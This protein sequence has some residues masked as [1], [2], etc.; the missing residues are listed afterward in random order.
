MFILKTNLSKRKHH[1]KRTHPSNRTLH[2]TDRGSY[3]LRY[4]VLRTL[5]LA[6]DKAAGQPAVFPADLMEIIMYINYAKISAN[7]PRAAEEMIEAMPKL[8]EQQK[9]DRAHKNW[10]WKEW[11]SINL[12][13]AQLE[14]QDLGFQSSLESI[15]YQS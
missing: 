7:A 8:T 13:E 12:T 1:E 3:R 14:A 4:S 5:I 6:E 2:S 15:G 11:M 9:R 10:V